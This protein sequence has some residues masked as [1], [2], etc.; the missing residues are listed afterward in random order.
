MGVDTLP[1]FVKLLPDPC[2]WDGGR[3]CLSLPARGLVSTGIINRWFVRI[4]GEIS[5]HFSTLVQF[6]YNV[7]YSRDG[8]ID[9]IRGGKFPMLLPDPA[10]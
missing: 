2:L 3:V 5:Q 7:M 1:V 9:L 6:N 8:K 4:E 10:L